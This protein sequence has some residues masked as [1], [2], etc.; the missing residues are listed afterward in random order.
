MQAVVKMGLFSKSNNVAAST[1]KTKAGS[2]AGS[3][4]IWDLNAAYGFYKAFHSEWRNVLVHVFC[5]PMIVFSIMCMLQSDYGTLPNGVKLTGAGG[6][7]RGPGILP[8]LSSWSSG[9]LEKFLADAKQTGTGRGV[10]N[11]L[12]LQNPRVDMALLVTLLYC[13]YYWIID[14]RAVGSTQGLAWNLPRTPGVKALCMS[15]FFLAGVECAQEVRYAKDWASLVGIPER[16]I[17]KGQG[18]PGV[19][20][21]SAP[22]PALQSPGFQFCF[23]LHL[24]SWL[25]QFAAHAWFEKKRPAL[26]DS[27]L[28][29]FLI[30]PMFVFIDVLDVMGGDGYAGVGV[31]RA[32]SKSGTAAKSAGKTRVKAE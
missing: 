31:A 20:I 24:F 32:G 28:Q 16:L 4:H 15:M 3:Q 23:G 21:G 27:L 19:A 12:D 30:A 17:L 10:A 14:L 5:I 1:A 13:A 11:M 2:P 29:A 26:M 8:P 18:A 22:P 6:G 9:S 7:Y 25:G